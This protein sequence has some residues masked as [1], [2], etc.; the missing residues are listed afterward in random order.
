LLG[1][2][3]VELSYETVDVGI[4]SGYASSLSRLTVDWSLERLSLV[5]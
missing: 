4:L 1:I 3:L 5:E 2:Y